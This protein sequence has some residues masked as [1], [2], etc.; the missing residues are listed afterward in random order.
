[1]K[2][3]IKVTD[4]PKKDFDGDEVFDDQVT[5]ALT[6]LVSELSESVVDLDAPT[7]VL[8]PFKQY[9]S[10]H[11]SS[12]SKTKTEYVEGMLL[13]LN[14]IGEEIKT[15]IPESTI[16]SSIDSS[17]L[18]ND[19]LIGHLQFTIDSVTS[20]VYPIFIDLLKDGFTYMKESNS[21]V[22]TTKVNI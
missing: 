3:E 1:M 17:M 18:K 20:L 21:F 6:K 19:I 11:I 10:I 22:I 7:R 8:T 16:K 13:S 14:S 15:Y 12:R 2:G 9:L 5:D 4:N